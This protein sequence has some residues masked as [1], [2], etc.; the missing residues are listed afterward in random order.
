[1]TDCTLCPELVKVRSN[2]VP[3]DGPNDARIALVG[4]GPG[5]FEDEKRRP[6]IGRAGRVLKA[7]EW[8][9]GIDQYKCYHTNATLC[10]GKR[11]PK[12]AE[13][14]ACHPRLIKELR[15]LNP[16]VIVVLGGVALRSLCPQ[17]RNITSVMGF[18]L[19]NDELPGIP[20]VPTYHPSYIMRG[21]WGEVALVLA[22]FRKAKRISEADHWE[23]KLGSYMGIETLEDL[24]AL[25]DYLLGPG[26]ESISVDTE[27]FVVG[28]IGPQSCERR[29]VSRTHLV[30]ERR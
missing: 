5:Q 27:T 11:N 29:E 4:E 16:K 30:Q 7:M 2:T 1:M 22:H 15:A 9:A 13:V 10:W 23:E 18:T 8:A 12:P 3:G 24:R 25:R 6:F 21:H 19:Y 14:D 26:V 20:I 28:H 17:A